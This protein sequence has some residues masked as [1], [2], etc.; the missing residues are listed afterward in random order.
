MNKTPAEDVSDAAKASEPEIIRVEPEPAPAWWL[1]M[2]RTDDMLELIKASPIAFT[3]AAVIALRARFKPG[4]NPITG[5]DQ[6]EA[7]LGDHNVYGMS[8]QQ[9]RTAKKNLAKW[10]F[11]TF[12]L[13]SKGTVAKLTDTRLFDVLNVTANKRANKRATA[14]Q[15]QT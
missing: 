3:L 12:R 14:A 11:A 13:T 7:F 6:G 2:M 5:L 4:R 8:L 10:K 15:Q 1:K 9:Y